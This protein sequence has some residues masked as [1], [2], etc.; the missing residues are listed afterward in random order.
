MEFTLSQ[1]G[2]VLPI[3][4]KRMAEKVRTLDLSVRY[5]NELMHISIQDL[6]TLLR[7]YLV[8]KRTSERTKSAVQKLLDFLDQGGLDITALEQTT[9]ESSISAQKIPFK[10]EKITRRTKRHGAKRD[11]GNFWIL[12]LKRFL[13]NCVQSLESLYFKFFALFVAIFVQMHHTAVWFY[14]SAPEGSS[15]WLAAYGYA[16][17]LD[18]FILVVT[19]E[20]KMSIAKTFAGLTFISNLLYFQFWV[21]FDASIIAYTKAI[22]CLII[23]AT[24]AFI[25]YSYTEIFVKYRKQNLSTHPN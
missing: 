21:A 3:R 14:R 23:S 20:G 12:F 22:S 10:K 24:I 11:R 9:I 13:L 25:L 7:H 17:M 4:P 16:I 18:L 6:R 15:S 1:I 2:T 8:S 19:M 5:E